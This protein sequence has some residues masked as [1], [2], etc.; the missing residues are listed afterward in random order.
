MSTL[1][2]HPHPTKLQTMSLIENYGMVPLDWGTYP[3]GLQHDSGGCPAPGAA[4]SPASPEELARVAQRQ[5]N[6]SMRGGNNPYQFEKCPSQLRYE[7]G[8]G[9]MNPACQ[10][11]NCQGDCKCTKGGA[12]VE[13]F[14]GGMLGGQSP[15]FWLVAVI[16]AVLVYMYL[17]GKPKRK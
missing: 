12:I 13:G 11:Q 7:I 4:A 3:M 10:C 6:T 1:R 17:N 9:C 2:T 15:Q 8:T 14:L 16:V 5:A